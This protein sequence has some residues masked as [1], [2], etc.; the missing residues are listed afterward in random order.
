MFVRNTPKSAILVGKISCSWCAYSVSVSNIP[1]SRHRNLFE[2]SLLFS[3]QFMFSDVNI[4]TLL[5]RNDIFCVS[6][7]QKY[8]TS[9][10]RV[11]TRAAAI[12]AMRNLL[13]ILA[14]IRQN[15][16]TFLVLR[17]KLA[18]FLWEKPTFHSPGSNSG[19][20]NSEWL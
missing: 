10:A 16:L 13:P 12:S 6:P 9:V 7:L 5:R 17:Q 18:T 14:I 15:S 2:S 3:K 8:S 11:V 19:N 4:P 1:V 20:G